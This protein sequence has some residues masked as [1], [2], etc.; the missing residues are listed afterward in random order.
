M[1]ISL[2]TVTFN[3]EKTLYDTM[4]SILSQSYNE[5]EYTIVDGLSQDKTINIIKQHK[6]LFQDHLKWISEKDNGLIAVLCFCFWGNVAVRP[7]VI[8]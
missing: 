5:I 3:S 6:F 8:Y 1:K 2:I 4:C 7:R